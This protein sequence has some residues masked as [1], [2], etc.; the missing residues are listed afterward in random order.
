MARKK[1]VRFFRFSQ[2]HPPRAES[3]E[4]GLSVIFTDHVLQQEIKVPIDILALSAGMVAEDTDELA[5]IL[6]GTGSAV[7]GWSPLIFMMLKSGIC[8]HLAAMSRYGPAPQN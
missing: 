2:D 3:D 4:D 1:G 6:I 5:S 8:P 7:T